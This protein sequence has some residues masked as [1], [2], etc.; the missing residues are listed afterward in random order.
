MISLPLSRV[1]GNVGVIAVPEVQQQHHV[2]QQ[3]RQAGLV[4]R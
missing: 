2:A 1:V 3:A 4:N